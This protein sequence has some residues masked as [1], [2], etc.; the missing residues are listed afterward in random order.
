M[1]LTSAIGRGGI[2]RVAWAVGPGAATAGHKAFRDMDSG[3][4]YA[5]VVDAG[6]QAERSINHR[7]AARVGK[8]PDLACAD[9]TERR[10]I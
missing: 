10:S 8:G 4:R 7:R 5:D 6:S 3:H 9:A 2:V 1:A